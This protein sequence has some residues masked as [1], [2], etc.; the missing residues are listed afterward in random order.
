MCGATVQIR[1][2]SK[3]ARSK[4]HCTCIFYQ[5]W[6][7][8]QRPKLAAE[9]G[10]LPGVSAAVTPKPRAGQ[11]GQVKSTLNATTGVSI[12]V[13]QGGR[14]SAPNTAP[15][16]PAPPSAANPGLPFDEEAKLVYGVIISLRTMVKKLS[17]RYVPYLSQSLQQL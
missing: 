12:T 13:N 6:H 8:T 11:E 10:I 15:S 16:T 7:R 2:Q 3:N 9:N 14:P 5:D 4:R 17:G 1:N